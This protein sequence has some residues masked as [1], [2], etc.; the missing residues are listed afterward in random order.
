MK[1]RIVCLL[2]ALVM[3]FGTALSVSAAGV[4]LSSTGAVAE[5][6]ETSASVYGLCD[7]V[8]DGQILQC[9]CWSFDNIKA[10]LPKIAEQGFTAIQTSPIQ[11]IKESTRE[12]W[13]TLMGQCWVVY[14]PVAF[15]IEDNYRNA[16]GTKAEFKAMCAEAEKYGIKVIVDTIFNHT[17]NDMSENTVHP[18]VPSEIKD[19]SNCW[20]DIYTNISNY[21]NRYDITHYCLS[22]LPDLNTSNSIVQ[23]HCTN[24]LKECIDA[25]A[26]GFRFDAAKHI[27]TP[28]DA[29]G[30]KSD[31][32]PNVL[33]AATEYAQETK[34]FTPYYYG[35]I[36]GSPDGGLGIDAYTQYMSVTDT[37]AND[38]RQA[39]CDG[40]ASRAASSGISCGAAPSKTVQWTESHD[41]FKDDGTKFISD[42]NINKTWAIVGSR[43]EVC[44]LYLARPENMD[45]T[46]MGDADVTSWASTEVR[47]INKF[48]NLFTGKSE[49]MASSGSVAYIERGTS[50]VVLVNTGGTYYNNVSV[51]AHIIASGTYTDAITGNTFTV[52]NGYISGDI[53]DT[54]IA[55]VYDEESAGTLTKGSATDFSLVGTFNDWDTDANVMVA[56]DSAVA[57]TSMILDAGEYTFKINNGDLWFSNKGTISDT[58]GDSGWTFSPAVSEKC[59]LIATGG[60]YTFNFN[61]TTWKLTVE[62]S[63]S[64]E[65][66]VYIK[67]EFND[68]DS[69]AQMTYTKGSNT[70][71][72]TL[73]IPKGTYGFKVHNRGIGSWY[74][75]TGTVEDTTGD[76]GWTMRT[77]VD[78]NCTLKASGGTYTFSFNLST[79]KLT[80]TADLS[81]AV[82]TSQAVTTAPETTAAVTTA[83]AE[84]SEASPYYIKGEF[85]SWKD[86]NPLYFTEDDDILSATFDIEA[87][88]YGFKL[89]RNDKDIW[90]GNTGTINDTTGSSGWTMKEDTDKCTLVASGGTYTFSLAR[91]TKKLT[92]TYVPYE[93]ET[94]AIE[95]TVAETTAPEE[96]GSQ[97]FLRGDFNDWSSQNEM[98][99]QANSSLVVAELELEAGTYL[100]KIQDKANSRWY[101]N[102]GT[103]E[104]STGGVSW[105]MH[106]SAGDAT[107]VATG[108]TYTFVFDISER[109][110]TVNHVPEGENTDT[111]ENPTLEEFTV[112][113]KDY[114]G[115]VIDTQTVVEGDAAVP[116]ADPV[117]E[118][119]AQYSYIFTG[120]DTPF[121]VIT[122][123]TEI[124]ATYEQK[125]NEFEVKF[126]DFDG[127]ILDI[128]S[129][130]YGSSATSPATPSRF[131]YVFKA[132]D[133]EFG[134]I[135]EATVVTATY[136]KLPTFAVTW[137]ES[138]AYAVMSDIDPAAVPE[139]EDFTFK[140]TAAEGYSLTA[141]VVDMKTMT[142]DENGVYTIPALSKDTKVIIVT[143]KN[144]T[145]PEAM[146]FT[147][148]FTDKDGNILTEQTVKYGMAALAPEAPAVEGY[149]FTGWS[150][151]YE[152]VTKDI[153]VKA[154]YKKIVTPPAPATTGTLKVE[155]AGGT[156]FTIS[157]AGGAARP[158]GAT[159]YN[160]TAPIGATV[161][162][163][164]NASSDAEFIGWVNVANGKILST[165]LTYTFTTAGNDLIKAMYST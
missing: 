139:G 129:V 131:G 77:S 2:L 57:T 78:D 79:N 104:D 89:Y 155:L 160:A 52:S 137:E 32:W 69:S 74:S 119:T 141:V 113:F 67:G 49:Y 106:Q 153:T 154:E 3:A 97:I 36:L 75:N 143:T 162:V 157:I 18:W 44:G 83:P 93:E 71:E 140:V 12:S 145:V 134:N 4:D 50:G 62:H 68:W 22:G 151:D 30:T 81:E 72:A 156:N 148:T 66:G 120:W 26:D 40:N 23:E 163:T 8:Q 80:I 98:E 17:A 101:G 144:S 92:V 13:S 128:Q 45:T 117:R 41:N 43:N 19:N 164:A 123:D 108:G 90:Y 150:E 33:N 152:Y 15:N 158:Q 55:V 105:S 82:T 118:G 10:M 47:A 126:V 115:T 85:N 147:V 63:D 159:Y 121:V 122:G 51:P 149:T 112:T 99:A 20:H 86:T 16:F 61:T 48:K 25:G 114:D 14:Q 7:D 46:M 27:E 111:P 5:L 130:P 138:P 110:L 11:P 87:G 76:S 53:G 65:S 95:T 60:K 161:T 29:S 70:V 132:W 34:G 116:P 107:L 146:T 24:F 96:T 42:H 165:D 31:F 133:K 102:D 59:T 9:W 1:K 54:G 56:K 136:E 100:F 35:E 127:T 124:T 103:I 142:A 6:S 94:T 73:T 84:E 38:I 88:T 91:S 39:V 109:R 135:T 58:T 37:G 28:S 125:I 64:T 21:D